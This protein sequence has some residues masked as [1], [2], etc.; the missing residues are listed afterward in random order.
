MSRLSSQ[1]FGTK[2]QLV[3]AWV[4]LAS[5]LNDVLS[6][7]NGSPERI[8]Q[9]SSVS[10]LSETNRKLLAWFVNLAPELQWDVNRPISP[11]ICALHIQFLSI[12]ILLNRPF[13]TYM[14]NRGPKSVPRRLCLE[15]QTPQVSQQI[16]TAN[17]V[18][19]SKLLLTYRQHHGASKIFST[20]NPTCLTAAVALISDIMNAEPDED[21]NEERKWLAAILETLE[22]IIP[23]Y[24]IAERSRNTLAAVMNTCGLSDILQQLTTN[25][26]NIQIEMIP[27]HGLMGAP[28]TGWNTEAGLSFG[29]DFPFDSVYDAHNIG[30]ASFYAQPSQMMS[31]GGGE[32]EDSLFYGLGL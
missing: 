16:C 11:G 5:L 10:K 18:R 24:P 4:E 30:L 29:L 9:D 31:F 28:G 3:A 23:W 2:Y 17:A 12:T 22:E 6:V 15:G 1:T 20:I 14:L 13:A 26:A 21:K 7:I 32:T 25:S 27:D 19:I 8:Y